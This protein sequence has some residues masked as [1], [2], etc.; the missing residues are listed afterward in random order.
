MH[1]LLQLLKLI[2]RSIV[3]TRDLRESVK[4]CRVVGEGLA[5]VGDKISTVTKEVSSVKEDVTK[6]SEEVSGV[7]ATVTEVSEEVSGVGS[8]VENIKKEG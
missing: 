3:S 2:K 5:G 7:K 1:L 6:V 8:K 4:I